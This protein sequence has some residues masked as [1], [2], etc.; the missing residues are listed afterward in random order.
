MVPFPVP[1]S[2]SEFCCSWP[3][4]HCWLL[5]INSP[6]LFAPIGVTIASTHWCHGHVDTRQWY[7]GHL[8]SLMS[9]SRSHIDVPAT[10]TYWCHGHGG[11]W[12]DSRVHSGHT[13]PATK[14]VSGLISK[15]HRMLRQSSHS[16]GRCATTTHVHAGTNASGHWT[17]HS[18]LVRGST[19]SKI[20]C[21]KS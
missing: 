20:M 15:Q 12:C 6:P 13:E 21:E 11:H 8:H 1:V 7:H 14:L 5:L 19:L 2:R 17:V 16:L 18:S 3:C 10:V 9:R 4:P